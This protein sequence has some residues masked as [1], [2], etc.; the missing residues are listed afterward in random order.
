[1]D[2]DCITIRH[3]HITIASTGQLKLPVIRMNIIQ[4]LLEID[5]K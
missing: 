3:K 5:L 1:M 4:G 2:L